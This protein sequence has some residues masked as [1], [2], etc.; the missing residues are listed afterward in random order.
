MTPSDKVKIVVYI[1][2]KK[3]KQM[4]MPEL[5]QSAIL[6]HTV[7]TYASMVAAPYT[8]GVHIERNKTREEEENK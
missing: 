3:A 4:F 2:D 6:P 8:I 7:N 5:T 1:N